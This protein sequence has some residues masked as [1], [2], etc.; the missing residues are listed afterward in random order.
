[1]SEEETKKDDPVATAILDECARRGE[2]DPIDIAKA[3]AETRRKPKD[4]PELWRKYLPAVKQQAIF[5]SKTGRLEI[6]RKGQVVEW[7]D[8][9]GI[10]KLRLPQ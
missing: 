8:F 2:L 7:R 4:P 9:K 3:Y 5:L 1:M 6:T 10:C